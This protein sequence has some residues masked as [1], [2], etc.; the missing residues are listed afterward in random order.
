MP[1]NSL[2]EEIREEIYDRPFNQ[3]DFSRHCNTVA[4][5]DVKRPYSM[6][7]KGLN[8][9]LTAW[10][11]YVRPAWIHEAANA[12]VRALIRREDHNTDFNDLAPVNKAF[13]M[14]AIYFADGK[15]SPDLIRHNQQISTYLWQSSKGMT[16]G[17][18]NGLQLWDTAFTII[19]VAEAGL[20][21]HPQYKVMMEKALSFLDITQ[22]RDDLSDPYRQKRKGGWPFSTKD[23]GYIVS[24]CSA[25]GMKAVLLLQEEWYDLSF[26]SRSN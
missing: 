9:V 2:L 22:F 8:S 11:R 18:T 21:T 20:A 17:G 15:H 7:L 24:D 12:R 14:A 1:L 19:A 6:F 13:H 26:V 10:E 4:A 5:T 23:N 16:S 25:E 3:I